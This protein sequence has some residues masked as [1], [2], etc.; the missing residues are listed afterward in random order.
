MALATAIPSDT[1]HPC[2]LLLSASSRTRL[3]GDYSCTHRVYQQGENQ[4]LIKG[5]AAL[6]TS[7]LFFL[8]SPAT[9]GRRQNADCRYGFGDYVYNSEALSP[10][11]AFREGTSYLQLVCC[12]IL[13]DTQG[14]ICPQR[15][16]DE[17]LCRLAML[18]TLS[19]TGGT[20]LFQ[21]H[22][23]LHLCAHSINF[24]IDIL[25]AAS[26]IAKRKT[27]TSQ[28]EDGEGSPPF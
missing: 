27:H 21:S 14:M 28:N 18:D 6:S 13:T 15:D 17:S 4:T 22:C 20:E 8:A 26:Y 11:S 16:C 12:A 5:R 2:F 3:I 23:D 7:G 24:H 19:N 9:R 25:D 1:G 10:T